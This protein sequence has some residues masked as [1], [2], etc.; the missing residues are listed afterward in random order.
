MAIAVLWTTVTTFFDLAFVLRWNTYIYIPDYIFILFTN[1]FEDFIGMRYSIIAN[2]VINA[3]I[4]PNAVEASVFA[5]LTGLSNLGYGLI[6]SLMGTFWCN[7]LDINRTSL[8]NF[9]KG[10]LIKLV[11]SVLP[12]FLLKLIPNKEEIN[13]DEDLKK[14]NQEDEKEHLI[15]EKTKDN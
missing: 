10:L 15:D 13:N 5:I 14:L 8:G 4:T 3:R 7:L 1:L 2:G 12:L 9:Y 6:G 11:L